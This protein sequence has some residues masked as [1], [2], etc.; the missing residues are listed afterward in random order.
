MGL[1]MPQPLP[2]HPVSRDPPGAG[3]LQS[4]VCRIRSR[5]ERKRQ[6]SNTI[7]VANKVGIGGCGSILQTGD[8]LTLT[9]RGLLRVTEEKG[10][11]PGLVEPA[12]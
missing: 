8:F 6:R 12:P 5:R 1:T 7:F 4:K 9:S 3:T 11:S 2:P 10:G